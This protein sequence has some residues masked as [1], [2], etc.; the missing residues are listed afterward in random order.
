[1][2][3]QRLEQSHV[4]EQLYIHVYKAFWGEK[5][6]CLGLAKS[7]WLIPMTTNNTR[8]GTKEQ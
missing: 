2:P 8:T 6:T 5:G 3:I 4:H 7:A 1:M